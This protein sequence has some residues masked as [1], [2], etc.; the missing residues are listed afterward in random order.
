MS[1]QVLQVPIASLL[2]D[3]NIREIE[4]D[5]AL[6]D[7]AT[8]IKTHGI[9]EPVVVALQSDG[10]G[11]ERFRLVAGYRRTAAAELAGLK[12]VPAVCPGLATESFREI[13]LI[14]NV[15]RQD[16]A[17]LEE[18]KALQELVQAGKTQEQV[19]RS[20]GKSQP[21]VANRIRLLGLPDKGAKMLEEGK[22]SPAA[23]EQ[24]LKLPP[25]ADREIKHA[26][27]ELE[28][29]AGYRGSVSVEEARWAADSASRLFRERKQCEKVIAAAKF[30]ECPVKSCGKTGTIAER[31]RLEH[32][33]LRCGNGHC[34]SPKTGEVRKEQRGYSG[35]SYSP[36]PKPTLPEVNVQV[37]TELQPAQL[38]NRLLES[39]KGI[40]D[41][42]LDWSTGTKASLHLVVD[43]PSAKGAKV[44][45]FEFR[46]GH[47]FV[48]LDRD[49]Y[50]P[51]DRARKATA[52]HRKD[53]ES[54]LA[55][56]GKPGRKPGNSA[57]NTGEADA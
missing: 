42:E 14:E 41:V 24:I 9:I 53:L 56:F 22:L 54:W 43:L 49:R 31:W 39:A 40:Y 5:D 25:G 26:F 50:Q 55:T 45:A 48:E 38:A 52:E 4:K 46:A 33:D 17:P 16:L 34:W 57:P 51:D 18:A 21:Y 44:P 6:K 15:Q 1:G 47:K 3:A 30:P 10:N 35:G 11:R 20:I 7:L 2:R 23:A 19:A 8:S 29:K 32:S 37:L 27:A 28:R 13:Q 36:P 12:T